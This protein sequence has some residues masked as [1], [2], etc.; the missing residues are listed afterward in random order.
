MLYGIDNPVNASNAAILLDSHDNVAIARLSLP[1]QQPVQTG[2]V[3]LVTSMA[4]PSGHKLALRR[5]AAGEPVYR[6]GNV[7]GFATR[8]IEPGEHV[9]VHNLGFKELNAEDIASTE[10]SA[11]SVGIQEPATFLGYERPDGRVGTRNYIAVVAASN[12]AAYTA[13]LIARSFANE[14]LPENFDGV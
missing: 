3:S 13:E 7:I 10:R 8:A 6:Y 5:I 1:A 14:V 4:I 12:C 2:G 9:H 11:R